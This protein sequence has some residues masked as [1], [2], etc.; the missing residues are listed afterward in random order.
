MKTTFWLAGEYFQYFTNPFTYF[1]QPFIH[2]IDNQLNRHWEYIYGEQKIQG[3]LVEFRDIEKCIDGNF[4]SP[5]NYYLQGS[6]AISSPN[7]LIKYS[8]EGKKNMGAS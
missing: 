4:I 5:L 6:F 3:E 7:I 8:S 2:K 1:A